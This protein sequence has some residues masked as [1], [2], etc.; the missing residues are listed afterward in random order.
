MLCFFVSSNHSHL[1][2]LI[3]NPYTQNI[4]LHREP[5]GG[6]NCFLGHGVTCG[7][8]NRLLPL[9]YLQS[10]LRVWD[11]TTCVKVLLTPS[12]QQVIDKRCSSLNHNQE[13]RRCWQ[14]LRRLQLWSVDFLLSEKVIVGSGSG[15]EELKVGMKEGKVGSEMGVEEGE[16]EMRQEEW[17]SSQVFPR[18]WHKYTCKIYTGVM[19]IFPNV[20]RFHF[21]LQIILWFCWTWFLFWILS[22]SKQNIVWAWR[23]I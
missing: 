15:T 6:R 19:N 11:Y 22:V 16:K 1:P 21:H 4:F 8:L 17:T 12:V 9:Q 18:S 14:L 2:T 3:F 23:E 5:V 20:G 10:Q 7:L 13:A